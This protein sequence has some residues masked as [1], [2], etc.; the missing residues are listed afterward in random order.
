MTIGKPQYKVDVGT[1]RLK[2]SLTALYEVNV[3]AEVSTIE[4]KVDRKVITIGKDLAAT[5]TASELMVGI[6]SVNVDPQEG[7]ISLSGNE[8][9]RVLVDGRLSN[10]PTAQLLKQIPSSAIKSIEIITNPSAKYNPEGMS[11]IINIVLHKNQ[12][13]GFNGSLN[14][15]WSYDINPKFNSGLNLN[16]RMESLIFMEITAITFLK[17]TTMEIFK[18]QTTTP[19]SSLILEMTGP[20]KFLK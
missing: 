1:I 3:I 19:N 4:Q 8:N 16:Y 11:G 13:L 9:V 14:A 12:M 15:N 7:T 2:E 20:L 10:I 17:T 18:E 6:P 5:G